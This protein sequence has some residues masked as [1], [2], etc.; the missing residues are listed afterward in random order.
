ML[1][2]MLMF[3][4]LQTGCFLRDCYEIGDGLKD[5]EK[6]FEMRPIWHFSLHA[7]KSYEQNKVDCPKNGKIQ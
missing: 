4:S 5:L 7:F 6:I 2:T 3:D 1:M